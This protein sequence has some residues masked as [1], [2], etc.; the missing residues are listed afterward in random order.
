MS[1][2]DKMV[3]GTVTVNNPKGLHLRV[4]ESFCE[5]ALK[6]S[7]SVFIQSK[8]AKLNGK[9]ILGVLGACVKQGDEIEI[10]CDGKDEEKALKALV[11]LVNSGLGEKPEESK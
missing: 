5:M 10:I 1:G 4:A 3:S 11:E 6:Y 2:G 9:S 7:C 8:N